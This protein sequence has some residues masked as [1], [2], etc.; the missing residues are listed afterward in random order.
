MPRR[1]RRTVHRS[2]SSGAESVAGRPLQRFVVA[3]LVALLVISIAT[4]L[5]A[6]NTARDIALRQAKSQGF[7][8]AKAMDPSLNVRALRHPH[9]TP[10]RN[11]KGQ[12]DTRLD[13]KSLVHVKVLNGAGRVV[14]SDPANQPGDTTP[15]KPRVAGILGTKNVVAAMSDS[16][17]G[18]QEEINGS[19]VL[20]VHVGAKSAEGVPL[21]IESWWSAGMLER[22]TAA[23]M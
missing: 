5:V 12:I 13:D 7:R 10:A 18:E 1:T 14:W 3:G 2:P 6:R 16:A 19:P 17:E 8:L 4:V 15:L 21:V 22:N 23:I 11:L 20:E 9:S